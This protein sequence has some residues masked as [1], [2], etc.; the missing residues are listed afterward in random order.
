MVSV[1]ISL[2]KLIFQYQTPTVHSQQEISYMLLAYYRNNDTFWIEDIWLFYIVLSF[3][4]VHFLKRSCSA[5]KSSNKFLHGLQISFLQFPTRLRS[6]QTNFQFDGAKSSGVPPILNTNHDLE[7]MFFVWKL[8]KTM[9]WTH[10]YEFYRVLVFLCLV[11]S[12]LFGA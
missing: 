1:Y 6:Y 8:V 5:F 11:I 7:D 3:N 12:K 9:W 10:F 2:F 4:S